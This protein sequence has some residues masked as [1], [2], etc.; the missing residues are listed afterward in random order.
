MTERDPREVERD[1]ESYVDSTQESPPPGFTDWVM[2][3][4]TGEPMPRRG[5][6]ASLALLVGG[7]GPTRRAAQLMAVALLLVA[8]IGS[9]VVVGSILDEE[10]SPSP[11]PSIEPSPS[12]SIS[13]EPSPTPTEAASPTPTPTAAQPVPTPDDDLDT[14][15]PFETPDPDETPEP[16]D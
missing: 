2:R 8:M 10:P 5:V 6:L 4:V 13:V 14:P 9:A 3:S 11:T 15:E 1:L 12:P 7:P 16:S